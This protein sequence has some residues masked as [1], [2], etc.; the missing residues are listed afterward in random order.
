MNLK[1]LRLG[2]WVLVGLVAAGL[3]VFL[4]QESKTEQPAFSQTSL[5]T[6]GGPFNLT[7]SSGK[8]FS[9]AEL[10]GKPAAVFFGFTHC[11]DVCPTTLARLTKLRRDLGKG[12]DALSIV[13]ISVDPERDTPAEVDTYMKLYDTPVIGLTGTPAQ[14][15]QVKK[16]FG[17][18]SRKVEQ[19]G[20]GYSVDHTA[21]VILLDRNGQFSSTIAMEEGNDVALA[22]LR[23]ITA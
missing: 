3:V 20:G 22:K 12:N 11:P 15:E 18:F 5:G 14:I 10:N 7:A 23:R 1:Q 17:I 13:F 9:S 16:Q 2:L 8:P 19:P 4:W 21:T 6:I